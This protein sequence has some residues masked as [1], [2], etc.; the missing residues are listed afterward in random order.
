MT[1]HA[2]FPHAFVWG[3]AT[4]AF[5]VEGAVAEDGKGRSIWDTFVDTPGAIAGGDRADVA[6]DHYHRFD[7]DIALL[8]DLGLAAY[9]FSICWPRVQPSG[10]GPA[11]QRGLD[12]YRRVVDSCLAHGVTPYVT[13]YHWDLPQALEDA[14]GW[15][16]RD[17][18]HRFVDYAALVGDALGDRVTRWVTVNEP[19]VASFAGYGDGIHA[20]GVKDPARARA[21]AHHL[22]VG[23]GLAVPVLRAASA[24][25]S[26]VGLSLD[27]SPAYAASDAPADLEAQRL[28][29]LRFNRMWLDPV[30]RGHFPEDA[31]AE[32]EDATYVRDGDLDV[33]STPIDYLG[34]NYYRPHVVRAADPAAS[35]I[36]PVEVIP[37]GARLTD[38]GW[39]DVPE[40]FYDLLVR[41]RNEYP[42]TP[43]YIT[44]NGAAYPE[45]TAADGTVQDPLRREYLETHLGAIARAA[46]DGADVRG[47]FVWTL[48]DNF[49]WAEG[50]RPRFGVVRVDFDTLERTPKESGRWLGAVARANALPAGVVS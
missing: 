29:D 37:E 5:Q 15:P 21:A 25:G 2:T 11:E 8:A 35:V 47:Y 39:T 12:H 30:L 26:L 14:G 49:E 41:L 32:I 17:T 1:A 3:A 9:R 16:A 23:H 22:L 45:Q 34:I 10:K 48:M 4:A 38:V 42:G 24:P 18:A 44:E 46:A 43:L 31:G 20:P 6:C 19:K 13:L 27:L 40:A 33:V 50:Y 28:F 36:R 7:D